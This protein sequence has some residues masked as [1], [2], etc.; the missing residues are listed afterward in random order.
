MS[1][2]RSQPN[3]LTNPLSER[4]RPSPIYPPTPYILPYI[5]PLSPITPQ[6]E[7]NADIR[8]I[9]KHTTLRRNISAQIEMAIGNILTSEYK[10]R[11]PEC[12]NCNYF[13]I[14]RKQQIAE[15]LCEVK[16]EK[17]CKRKSDSAKFQSIVV[18]SD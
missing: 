12:D 10:S 5:K 14:D 1:K 11:V 17:M 18:S 8:P 6:S 2:I 13:S 9:L 7:R 4:I 16:T 3:Q 15:K